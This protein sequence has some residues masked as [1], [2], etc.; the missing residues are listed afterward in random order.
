MGISITQDTVS[1]STL[2][3]I[4]KGCTFIPEGH[5]F[6]YVDSSFICN[7]QNLEAT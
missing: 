5:L 6:N 2:R 4:P 7:S 3:H 1:N